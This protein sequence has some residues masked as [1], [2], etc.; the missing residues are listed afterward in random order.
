MD[1][2]MTINIALSTTSLVVS[3]IA[4]LLFATMI[5]LMLCICKKG[6]LKNTIPKMKGFSINPSRTFRKLKP[7]TSPIYN[8]NSS[9]DEDDADAL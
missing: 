3:L 7:H 5:V 1:K 4:I 8:P 9:D 2:K 6:L